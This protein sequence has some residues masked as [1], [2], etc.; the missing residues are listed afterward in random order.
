M[1]RLRECGN[2]QRNLKSESRLKL[3]EKVGVGTAT[4]FHTQLVLYF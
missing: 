2:L 1:C 4:L 3:M